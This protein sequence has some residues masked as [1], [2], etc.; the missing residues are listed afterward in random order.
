M[1]IIRWSHEKWELWDM[2]IPLVTQKY[3]EALETLV[4]LS[5]ECKL[6]AY[7]KIGEILYGEHAWISVFRI[8]SP[9]LLF[10]FH[11]GLR[12]NVLSR[13]I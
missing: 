6:H 7:S 12:T 5:D 8:S 10:L 2:G 13:D 3:V 11:Q 4:P 9:I 1:Y